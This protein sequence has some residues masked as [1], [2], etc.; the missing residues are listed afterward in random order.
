MR[1]LKNLQSKKSQN[2]TTRWKQASPKPMARK[3]CSN[4]NALS[5]CPAA[6]ERTHARGPRTPQ[7]GESTRLSS[8]GSQQGQNAKL[9]LILEKRCFPYHHEEAARAAGETG[10]AHSKAGAACYSAHSRL[11]V[12]TNTTHLPTEPT[13]SPPYASSPAAGASPPFVFLV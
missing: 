6:A 13:V 8:A 12:L 5:W 3:L 4:G 10:P 1:S 9:L 11:R 7:A 2:Q